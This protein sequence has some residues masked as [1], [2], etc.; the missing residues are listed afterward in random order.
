MLISHTYAVRI[1]ELKNL[2]ICCL[3]FVVHKLT[4][5][6]AASF[7]WVLWSMVALPGFSWFSYTFVLAGF[8]WSINSPIFVQVSPGPRC[9][10][11]CVCAACCS[12]SWARGASWQS[13]RW[14][15]RAA[16]PWGPTPRWSDTAPGTLSPPTH[17][18]NPYA[19]CSPGHYTCMEKEGWEREERKGEERKRKRR[20]RKRKNRK[21]KM[22]TKRGSSS[23]GNNEACVMEYGEEGEEQPGKDR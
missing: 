19:R 22:K 15:W 20:R 16:A 5:V 8:V 2:S 10:L 18:G 11:T 12:R 13:R 4:C 9:K 7:P 23:S 1:Q 3:V 6:C 17:S 21:T 14:S